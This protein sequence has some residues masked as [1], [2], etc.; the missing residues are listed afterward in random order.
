M[1]TSS[2]KCRQSTLFAV[3]VCFLVLFSVNALAIDFTV[4]TTSDSADSN[5]GDRECRTESGACSLRAAVQ[6]ANAVTGADVINIPTGLFQLVGDSIN[7]DNALSGDLDVLDDLTVR[8]AGTELTRIIGAKNLSGVFSIL[9]NNAN[10][11]PNVTIEQLTL[12]DGLENVDG[13]VIYTEGA[14]S[15]RSVLVE[16]GGFKSAAVF[17]VDTRLTIENSVFERNN[18]SVSVLRSQLN[19]GNSRFSNSQFTSGAPLLVVNSNAR[20]DNNVFSDNQGSG[21]SG[22]LSAVDSKVSIA[23]NTFTDNSSASIGSGAVNLNGGTYTLTSNVFSRNTSARTGGAISSNATVYARN[24][25][26]D[27]N[28]SV[29]FGGAIEVD[30]PNRVV[31]TDSFFDSNNAQDCGAISIKRDAI[32]EWLVI[33]NS[34][35]RNNVSGDVGGALC[36]DN[37]VQISHSEFT[38]NVSRTSGGA[39]YSFGGDS[40][41]VNSTISGN[42]A[43][44][45]T[46][47]YQKA[48]GDASLNLQHVTIVDNVSNKGNTASIVTETGRVILAGS[49]VVAKGS[50]LACNGVIDSAGFN[51]TSDASCALNGQGDTST[52]GNAGLGGLVSY[53]LAQGSTAAIA[54]AHM[55]AIGS[56]LLGVVPSDQCPMLDQAYKSRR[57]MQCD[58]GAVQL[59]GTDVLAGVVTFG[60]PQY[61]VNEFENTATVKVSRVDGSFGAI[62]VHL[63]DSELGTAKSDFDYAVVNEQYLQWAD[64]DATDKLIDIS[65]YDDNSEEGNETIQLAL[66][67]S[68]GGVPIGG[69]T[70]TAIV[71]IIDDETSQPVANTPEETPD[72]AEGNNTDDSTDITTDGTNGSEPAD[73]AT[74]GNTEV[75]DD[76]PGGTTPDAE[77]EPGTR[78]TVGSARGG[79]GSVGIFYACL[80]LFCLSYRISLGKSLNFRIA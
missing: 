12:A 56:T 46:A 54:Q 48:I 38:G 50:D 11:S 45:G 72:S 42:L 23:D 70:D 16:D 27:G 60:E 55:P 62:G 34:I 37:K 75:L 61:Q 15:L 53:G 18:I 78:I 3:P 59:N 69:L 14:L 47:V 74:S 33:E 4:N 25:S 79:S 67:G 24:N 39:I 51:F 7:E 49:V 71:S 41:V 32:A 8:G 21:G 64:G 44:Y 40:S 52:G 73:T 57:G 30:G 1:I 31:I 9:S 29:R 80:L 58:I 19:V 5:P 20:L 68:S 17:A 76:Q 66:A 77:R 35:F 63:Y 10:T 22:A 65:L 28:V 13:G 2:R 36:F 26:F 6:E 43:V